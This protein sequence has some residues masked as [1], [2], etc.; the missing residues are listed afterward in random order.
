[1][2]LGRTLTWNSHSSFVDYILSEQC[3]YD[4]TGIEQ[5]CYIILFYFQSMPVVYSWPLLVVV[6]VVYGSSRYV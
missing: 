6:V 2:G 5:F 1:M 4:I 3:A